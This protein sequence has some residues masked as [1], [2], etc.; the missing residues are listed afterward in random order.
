MTE[1]IIGIIGGMGPEATVDFMNRIIRA[2]PA[3][4]DIDHIRL[5]VDNNPKIPSRMKAILEQTGEDPT[6]CLVEMA[7]KLADWGADI[8]TIPCN[9]AHYYYQIIKDAID[10][11]VLNMIELT[12]DAVIKDHPDI[13]TVLPVPRSRKEFRINDHT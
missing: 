5:I 7:R 4:D 6:P 9:T 12:V 13:Q 1:K 10:I 8:L 11:P 2:T 3:K